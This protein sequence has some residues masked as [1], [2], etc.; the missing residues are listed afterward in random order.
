MERRRRS[1]GKGRGRWRREGR[2]GR[3]REARIGQG[4]LRGGFIGERGA[5]AAVPSHDRGRGTALMRAV[6][7]EEAGDDGGLELGQ[8]RREEIGRASCRERVYVLV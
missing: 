3:R 2:R 1:R 6:Q 4:S 5:A 7:E 8:K